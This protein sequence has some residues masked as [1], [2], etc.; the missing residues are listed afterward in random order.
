MPAAEPR[1]P[2]D[3]LPPRAVFA[4]AF[5]ACAA[6][7]GFGYYLEYARGLAPCNLCVLQRVAFAATGLVGL[8]GALHGPRTWGQRVYGALGMV[9]ALTGAGLAGRHLWLQSLPPDAV[10]AC[11]PGI[12]YLVDAFPLHEALAQVL[13]GSGD[14]AQAAPWAFLG[15]G[16]PHWALVWF[17]ALALGFGAVML[18]RR[19]R[20]QGFSAPA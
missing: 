14:C 16:I 17:V 11:G 18:R 2:E 20:R 4:V 7:L 13:R 5:A 9:A 8:A 6:L 12:G 1:L 10:P 15:L 19:P 3:R